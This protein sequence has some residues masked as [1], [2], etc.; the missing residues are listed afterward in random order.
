MNLNEVQA[1][2][3]RIENEIARGARRLS[4]D[5]EKL[6][7]QA[8]ASLVNKPARKPIKK[9]SLR[10]MNE[11]FLDHQMNAAKT[12]GK[13]QYQ[14]A[15]DFLDERNAHGGYDVV[16]V[17]MS[18]LIQ[19]SLAAAPRRCLRTEKVQE[20]DRRLAKLLGGEI[21][22]ENNQPVTVSIPDGRVN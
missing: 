4:K 17:K 21:L 16:D 18:T 13:S 2:V 8:K 6:L 12:K 5:E 20:M 15:Q 7:A 3:T 10:D 11:Q 1:L 19:E 22:D 14:I 9:D